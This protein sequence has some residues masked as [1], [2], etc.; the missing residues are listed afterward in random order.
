MS[1]TAPDRDPAA[2]RT[3]EG[4]SA[5]S[6]AEAI[7]GFV[8]WLQPGLRVKRYLV[9]ALLGIALL[10]AGVDLLFLLQL[11]ELG[12]ELN[13]LLWEYFGVSLREPSAF[14]SL[15]YQ[16]LIGLP[17]AALGLMLFING[18]YHILASIT[19]AVVPDGEQSIVDVIWRR[20][21]LAHGPRVV[22]IGGG[23]G[24]STMLRGLKQ[25][26]SNITAVV[27]VTDDGGSSGLLQREYGML[28]PGDIRNCLVALADAE[29]LM[30][31][32]FQYRFQPGASGGENGAG[33]QGHSFGNILI[34][35]MQ[36]ITGDFEEAVR[37][38]SRVLAI[39][40]RVL[41]STTSHVRLRAEFEDGSSVEGE[42]A[43]TATRKRITSIELTDPTVEPLDEAIE[44]IDTAD[45][46]VIG[47]GSLFTSLLPNFL[48]E[49]LRTQVSRS[50]AIKMY[51]CNVMTQPGETDGFTAAD[52]VEA[53]LHHAGAALFD[54]VLVNSQKPDDAA[55][56]RYSGVGAEWVDPDVDR[57]RRVGLRP[58]RGA[59][60]NRSNVVRHDADKL[61]R[62][63]MRI[64]SR[65]QQPIF[66]FFDRRSRR[67]S[68]NRRDLQES[69]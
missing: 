54:Y 49:E 32:L 11:A 23:T 27:T 56:A 7:R 20:R 51:V 39:R 45:I 29:P 48:I 69:S 8:K 64:A 9:V 17:L 46:I 52:H 2:P 62:M 24:L 65:R 26:T 58:V 55:L 40:G 68:Q 6:A 4:A 35:A 60:I 42:S 10:V 16:T 28:P 37:Q 34:A 1:V 59:F 22:V 57:I 38:T 36:H 5:P 61:A 44:A 21:Q 13:I 50:S 30:Q 25:Y 47:P 41:P 43:I 66:W 53:L 31:Q 3:V 63:I 14:Q 67:R 15:P 19:S 12:D 33:L 18:V